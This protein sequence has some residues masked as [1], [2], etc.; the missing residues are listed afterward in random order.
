MWYLRPLACLYDLLQL[1]LGQ[2]KGLDM[3]RE[4]GGR[5]REAAC[6]WVLEVPCA[7]W[8]AAGLGP[9]G[10]GEATTG[11][12]G[13]V[14]EWWGGFSTGSLFFALISSPLP[15]KSKAGGTH[16]APSSPFICCGSWTHTCVFSL[17]IA[18][19]SSTVAALNWAPGMLL[20]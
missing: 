16:P 14:C 19:A 1:G 6:E 10:C 20:E 4:V 12:E 17:L 11:V 3:R 8:A 5:G 18:L 2:R 7:G 13:A 15:P 9:E